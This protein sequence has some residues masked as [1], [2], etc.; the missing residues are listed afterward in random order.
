M[1]GARVWGDEAGRIWEKRWPGRIGIARA[2]QFRG[3]LRIKEFPRRDRLYEI[4]D[5]PFSE[6]RV[7]VNKSSP[8]QSLICLQA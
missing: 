2:I 7:R 1:E 3:S 8:F 4:K 6:I 5:Y